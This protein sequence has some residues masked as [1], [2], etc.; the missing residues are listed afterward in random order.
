[1]PGTR[2]ASDEERWSCL[3]QAGS[4]MITRLSERQGVLTWKNEKDSQVMNM[5]KIGLKKKLVSAALNCRRA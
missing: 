3:I 5:S 4:F 2:V 1:M